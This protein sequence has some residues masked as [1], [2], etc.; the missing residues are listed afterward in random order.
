MSAL[1]SQYYYVVVCNVPLFD[2]DENE[3]FRFVTVLFDF[4]PPATFR[5]YMFRI[6][7][8]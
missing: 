7:I 8:Q 6:V 4:R 5:Y 1:L 2:G 3:E